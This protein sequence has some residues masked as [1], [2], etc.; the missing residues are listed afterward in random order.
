MT[1]ADDPVVHDFFRDTADPSPEFTVSLGPPYPRTA[2][3]AT[4]T[5]QWWRQQKVVCSG[6]K[7]GPACSYRGWSTPY[8]ISG[9]N[10]PAVM[11]PVLDPCPKCKAPGIDSPEGKKLETVTLTWWARHHQACEE[12]RSHSPGCPE[13]FRLHAA[14]VKKWEQY[15]KERDK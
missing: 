7:K 3:L 8:K 6:P 9:P 2:L 4:Y 1:S 11:Q 13:G 10:E 12:C 14:E 5:R 15:V